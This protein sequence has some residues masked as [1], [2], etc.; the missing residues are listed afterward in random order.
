MGGADGALGAGGV[1]VV[2]GRVVAG[3][4]G[5]GGLDAMAGEDGVVVAGVDGGGAVVAGVVPPAA[6]PIAMRAAARLVSSVAA[7]AR[8]IRTPG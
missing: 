2:A 4:S 3:W 8:F 1:G 6:Q 7:I 5:D